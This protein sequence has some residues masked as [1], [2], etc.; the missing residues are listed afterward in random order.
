MDEKVYDE[1]SEVTAEDGVVHVDG[2][3]GVD[4]H[5]TPNAA[6]EISD[7]IMTGALKARGQ[8]PGREHEEA[9]RA[10]LKREIDEANLQ[11]DLKP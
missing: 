4:V 1:G 5:L 8:Q 10:A 11:R 3:D 2:P 7:Q 9:R 6:L